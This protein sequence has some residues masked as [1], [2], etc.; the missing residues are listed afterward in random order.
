M[1]G[2]SEKEPMYG[3]WISAAEQAAGHCRS[4]TRNEL[5]WVEFIRLASFDSDPSPTLSRVQALRRVFS[6]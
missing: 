2:S 6:G 4:L 1:R 5:A 3:P